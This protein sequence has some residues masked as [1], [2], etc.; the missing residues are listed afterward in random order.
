V[1]PL[2]SSF[3]PWAHLL[4]KVQIEESP[5][6]I[7]QFNIPRAF[8]FQMFFHQQPRLK[9]HKPYTELKKSYKKHLAGTKSEDGKCAENS[10]EL[11]LHTPTGTH[12]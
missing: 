2:P 11:T 9:I 5:G 10:F 8:I 12:G 7:P 4:H 1:K 6:H 3:L